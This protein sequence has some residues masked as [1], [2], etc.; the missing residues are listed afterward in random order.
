MSG[1]LILLFVV[2]GIPVGAGAA[3]YDAAGP[4]GAVPYSVFVVL[5]Y[6]TVIGAIAN[7]SKAKKTKAQELDRERE[8]EVVAWLPST[9]ANVLAKLKRQNE[10]RGS[11]RLPG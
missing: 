2:V 3:I 1:F 5:V 10:L 9:R 7:R 8:A 4:A 6:L 11:C